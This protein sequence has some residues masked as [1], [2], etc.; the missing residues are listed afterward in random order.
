MI[1]K[2]IKGSRVALVPLP[3]DP[4]LAANAAGLHHVHDD[5]PGIRRR[6]H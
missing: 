1:T 5:G 6:R 4:V 2:H 3:M